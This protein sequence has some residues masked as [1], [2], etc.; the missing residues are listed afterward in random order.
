MLVNA[1]NHTPELA[2]S[3]NRTPRS[4]ACAAMVV[5][6]TGLNWYIGEEIRN[7]LSVVGASNGLGWSESVEN[8]T[9]V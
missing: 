7:G 8:E 9:S 1:A 3:T 4:T 2:Q 6:P 5:K